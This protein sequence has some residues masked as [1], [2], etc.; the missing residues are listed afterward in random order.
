MPLTLHKR[1][2]IWHFRGT[3]AGRRL[4]G[5]TGTADKKLAARIAAATEEREWQGRLAGPS[6]VLTFAQAA[7]LYR[8]AGKSPRF[9]DKVEDHWRDTPVRQITAGA[10]RQSAITLYPTCGPATRNRQVI[11]PTQ[12][13]INHAA[14]LGLCGAMK[15]A[16]FKVPHREKT[17]TTWA[18]VEAFMAA[19]SPHLGALCCFMHLTGARV[20]EAIDLR[21]QDVDLSAA[22][23]LIRQTKVAREREAHMPPVL[24]AA[25]ANIEGERRPGAKVFRYSSKDTAT[26]PWNAAVRRAGIK[27]LSFH[28]CRHGFATSMLH[29]GIDPV[30]VARRGG[31]AS[32]AQVFATYGHAMEDKTVSDRIVGTQMT[33]RTGSK[34]ISKAK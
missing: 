12:A 29:A 30:T 9:L 16:R 5:S 8:D 23:A 15:V 3:V 20:S 27:R 25:I 13:I 26:P 32:A 28:C 17:P 1:G 21:W 19:S 4:R 6:A 2:D 22:T 7:I 31:W 33:Q 14:E 34:L 10:I 11:A 24:V 18:W